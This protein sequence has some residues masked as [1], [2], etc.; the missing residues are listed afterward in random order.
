MNGCKK[1]AVSMILATIIAILQWAVTTF[2]QV[3]RLFFVYE[4][5]N[6]YYHI[7]KALFLIFLII[8]WNF[9]FIAVKKIR[10]K[11]AEWIRGRDFFVTYFIFSSV[12]L[13]LIWPGTW[14]S[15]DIN[16]I[17]H[18]STYSTWFP[19][20]H[21][22]T[23]IYQDVLLQLLPF[24]GG[25]ILLQNLLISI[26]V[27]FVVTKIEAT[28]NIKR[29][30]NRAIDLLVKLLP[31]ALPPVLMYQFSGYRMG[32]YIYLELVMLVMLI[33][34]MKDE[35]EWSICYISL[36]SVLCVLVSVWRTESFIYVP[37]VLILL[38]VIKKQVI[39]NNKKIGSA[40]CIVL[41]FL[42]LTKIQ[43]I[44]L[45]NSNYEV[46]SLL[47]PCVELVREADDIEDIE[48]LSS[49]DKVAD[50][51]IIYA[52]PDLRGSIMYWNT[53]V[54]RENYTR[55]DYSEFVSAIVKLS[56]KYPIVVIKERWRIFIDGSGITGRAI[57]NVSD[58]ADLYDNDRTEVTFTSDKAINRPIS[59]SLRAG[60][61]NLLG[62]RSIDGSSDGFLKYIVWNSIIPLIILICFWVFMLM[63][64]N[65]YLFFI[66]S[67]VL[68][69]LPIIVL[70]QPSPWFMYVISFYFLG[71]V[72]LIYAILVKRSRLVKV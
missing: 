50:L 5:K 29:L 18:I 56:V 10:E 19:W 55:E 25:V 41:G 7:T 14:A 27:A 43:N 24:P 21:I 45:G 44:S 22:L 62:M 63:K 69:R 54:V 65:W 26:C 2:L 58:A 17:N 11:K 20:Q 12:V 71:Y 47:G 66:S 15:D 6:N 36:F 33:C 39:P 1:K 32:I 68:I 3:D 28:Y 42:A 30:R 8:F 34:A 72:L 40:I 49:I 60:I 46:I 4:N 67:S 51:E 64:K 59:I 52:N 16:T 53:D 57:S 37:C 38:F 31:F 35:K 9:I 48:E 70:T 61:I 13:I 23:G